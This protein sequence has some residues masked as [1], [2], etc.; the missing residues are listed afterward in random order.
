MGAYILERPISDMEMH[1]SHQGLQSE[2]RQCGSLNLRTTD[3]DSGDALIALRGHLLPIS[4]HGLSR[5]KKQLLAMSHEPWEPRALRH[6]PWAWA[7]SHVPLAI[8]SMNYSIMYHM[9]W[10]L[11]IR[12]VSQ[13]TPRVVADARRW[14]SPPQM[15]KNFRKNSNKLQQTL[16]NSEKTCQLCIGVLGLYRGS[17]G[18]IRKFA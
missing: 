3:V 12:S 4:K 7:M 9:Y 1:S 17:I 14:S 16:E 8:E 5:Q 6:K 13:G 15:S 18:D 10:E 11:I 2:G